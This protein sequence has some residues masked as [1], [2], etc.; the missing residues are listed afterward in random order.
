MA[1]FEDR[2]YRDEAEIAAL[3]RGFEHGTLPFA[4]WTHEAHLTVA[5]WYLC[6]LAPEEATERIRTGI[7]RYN[8]ANGVVQTLTRGY[9]ETITRFSI[10]AVRR[11]LAERWLEQPIASLLDLTNDLLA[12][13]YG[14]R[15]FPL[16]Y[17]TREHLMSWEAR[18]GWVEPDRRPLEAL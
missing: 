15:R 4:L 16:D 5:V 3:V 7:Q 10:W 9:H 13:P 12:S 1:E 2:R 18:T 11:Y 14:D 6:H 8:L 17:Y